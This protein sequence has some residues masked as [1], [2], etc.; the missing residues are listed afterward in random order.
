MPPMIVSMFPPTFPPNFDQARRSDKRVSDLG[1]LTY[2]G[3]LSWGWIWKMVV[4]KRA[5]N[6]TSIIHPGKRVQ[7]RPGEGAKVQYPETQRQNKRKS[8][9]FSR[10]QVSGRFVWC[11]QPTGRP[12]ESPRCSMLDCSARKPSSKR[13]TLSCS[14]SSGIRI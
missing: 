6:W 10:N 4:E 1:R 12:S 13:D 3:K 2:Q 7:S 5:A 9:H 14:S 11:A 8:L